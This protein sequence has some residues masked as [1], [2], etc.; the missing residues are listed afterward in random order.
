MKYLLALL[1]P[2]LLHAD[3]LI[4]SQYV[5]KNKE[6]VRALDFLRKYEG[7]YNFGG[8]KLE[9]HVCDT[10]SDKDDKGELAGDVLLIDKRGREFYVPIYIWKAPS[11]LTWYEIINGKRVVNYKYKDFTPNPKTWGAESIEL[12]MYTHWDNPK[13]EHVEIGYYQRKEYV[14]E[15]REYRFKWAIC[16]EDAPPRRDDEEDGD[17]FWSWLK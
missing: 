11:D 1:L 3:P 10:Y 13:L 14:K 8:C 4:C 5:S 15:D 12:E 7:R 6:A 2:W 16:E 17:S 9:I